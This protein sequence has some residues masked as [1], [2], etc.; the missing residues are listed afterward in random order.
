VS[1]AA[2]PS[3]VERV[4]FGTGS[5]QDIDGWVTGVVRD[6][7]GSE[8]CRILFRS[9]RLDAVYGLDLADG[10]AVLLKVH[11]PPVDLGTRRATNTALRHLHAHGF[12]C[13]EPLHG[14]VTVDGRIIT[15]QSLLTQ[16]TTG[17]GHRPQV[18]Q[19]IA[20]ALAEHIALLDGL[21]GGV[22]S[23]SARLG[24]RPSW[25]RYAAGPWPEPHDPIYDFSVTPAGWEWLDR[26][27]RKAT[28][29]LVGLRD[30][31]RLALGHGDWS[32]GNLRFAH[33]RVVAAFD[34]DVVAE[35]EAVLVGLSAG[36]FLAD[37]APSP[38]EVAGFLDDY[39]RARPL[40]GQGRLAAVA[41]A[42]WILAY[43]A[44]CDLAFMQGEPVPGTP[45]Q[46][47]ATEREAYE[48]L[49]E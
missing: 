3:G 13:P 10:R 15:I 43:K 1:S 12:P 37:G 30:P 28:A 42:R 14:P 4:F 32:A 26:Y 5:R 48:S 2:A 24:R 38:Q 45:L 11:R 46:R 47:L 9:G 40:R 41:A 21:P 22:A 23:L 35:D 25:T 36:A 31:D 8:V 39:G 44:R 16:G 33:G 6:R 7:L 29:D 49:A 19:A 27:A 20:G 17:D 18:R 34:W